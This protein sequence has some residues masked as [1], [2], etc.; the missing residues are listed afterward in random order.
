MKP[1]QEVMNYLRG[2]NGTGP[3]WN[4][5]RETRFKVPQELD[6]LCQADPKERILSNAY[7]E[8]LNELRN[9]AKSAAVMRSLGEAAK[10]L[11]GI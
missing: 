1:S 2:R 4:A 9:T 3:F 6:R 7:N 11:L 5:D 10:K 8:L